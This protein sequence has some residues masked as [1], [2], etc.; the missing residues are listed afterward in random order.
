MNV[1]RNVTV[2]DNMLIN[3]FPTK[4]ICS[5]TFDSYSQVRIRQIVSEKLYMYG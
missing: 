5:I 4:L 2:K 3:T 1:L